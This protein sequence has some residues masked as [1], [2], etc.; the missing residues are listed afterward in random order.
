VVPGEEPERVSR[1]FAMLAA[2]IAHRKTLLGSRGVGD[3]TALAA[4]SDG[5]LR[6]PRIL[7][8][9]DG[10][11]G[12]ASAFERVDFGRLVETL[13]RFISDGRSVGVHFIIS[14]ERRGAIPSAIAALIPSRV[15]LRLAEA[16][17]YLALGLDARSLKGVA[18]PPGRGFA[19]GRELQIAVAAKG[20]GVTE[21]TVALRE[22][23]ARWSGA[24]RS[25]PPRPVSLL[26]SSVERSSLPTPT[27]ALACAIGIAESTHEPV[28]IDLEQGHLLIAGPYRSG[29][30]T[31]LAT[32]ALSLRS[33]TPNATL[34]LVAP[35][36][37][38]LAD[39]EVWD[40]TITGS[41]AATPYV[42][43]LAGELEAASGPLLVFVDDADELAEGPIAYA[44]EPLV[45]RGR[46]DDLRFVAAAE[47]HALLRAFGGWLSEMRK[48]KR[49]LLLDPDIDVDG[50]LL[51]VRLPRTDKT[52][53][54]PG[55]GYLVTRGAMEIIQ[56]GHSESRP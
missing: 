41:E 6:P 28:L 16:D 49:G 26:P 55:R 3:L 20:P 56:V 34:H 31:A 54:P 53:W 35:R 13:P 47:A 45:K 7:V 8:L 19:G 39:L 1:L 46:N 2:E 10:Y 14:T 29:R 17:D 32:V 51:G 27:K 24:P 11:A 21:E 18:L 15:I 52:S 23:A 44:L 37:S 30:S 12:F 9:L 25:A 40:R 43:S 4:E 48:D 42:E 36:R 50:D 38:P 33:T 5:A 22:I